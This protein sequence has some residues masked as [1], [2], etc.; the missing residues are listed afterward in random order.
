[1]AKV[2]YYEGN[3]SGYALAPE[4]AGATAPLLIVFDESGGSHVYVRDVPRRAEGGGH[5]FRDKR[6]VK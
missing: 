1:M 2:V 4:G 3:P 5:T 6:D